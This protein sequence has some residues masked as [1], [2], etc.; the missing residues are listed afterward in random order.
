MLEQEFVYSQEML[1]SATQSGPARVG[2]L[3]VLTLTATVLHKAM[4]SGR[5]RP[6]LFGCVDH[7]GATAG[8]YVVKLS[9]SMD[10]R[11]RGPASEV[12]ASY[13][14]D[15]FRTSD[16]SPRRW[17]WTRTWWRGSQS[18]SRSWRRC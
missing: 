15:H 2:R 10:T 4:T 17:N 9:G 11:D 18:K 1:V 8:D 3:L 12:I 6:L 13:L 14:A 7:E 16:L 5:N